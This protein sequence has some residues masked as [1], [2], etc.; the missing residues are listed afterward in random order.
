MAFFIITRLLFRMHDNK[1]CT[2]L[3]IWGKCIMHSFSRTFFQFL[4]IKQFS[5]IFTDHKPTII[6]EESKSLHLLYNFFPP[7][8][9]KQHNLS[10]DP[11]WRSSMW[12]TCSN[13]N[14]TMERKYN[15]IHCKMSLAI[16]GSG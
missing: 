13:G 10:S 4:A 11:Q 15:T 16:D 5:Y 3:N 9:E 12:C 8:N 7:I 6:R 1:D 2:N 14:K